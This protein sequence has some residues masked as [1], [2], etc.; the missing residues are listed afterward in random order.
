MLI[1]LLPA[2]LAQ[3]APA[4][5]PAATEPDEADAHTTD[6]VPELP[7]AL[8]NVS[9]TARENLADPDAGRLSDLL[10][11]SE[12]WGNNRGVWG[13]GWFAKPRVGVTLVSGMAKAYAPG[14]LGVQVG[15]R[16]FQLD[17]AAR[18]SWEASFTADFPTSLLGRELRGSL[19]AGVSGGWMSIRV[20]P[21]WVHQQLIVKGS[22]APL[23][24]AH[25]LSARVDGVISAGP[26][27]AFFGYEPIWWLTDTRSST[28]GAVLG[29][30]TIWHGGL[31]ASLFSL[32]LDHQPLRSGA[33]NR[34]GLGFRLLGGK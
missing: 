2:A 3:T 25:G 5:D 8:D 33:I 26:V 6:E 21:S 10:P 16:S 27:G 11:M 20:G 28:P 31:A 1:L 7:S 19:L 12:S 29:D 22:N 32:T 23:P 17:G 4:E 30:T 9:Q 18:L 15:R 14:S 24:S 34:I 13:G